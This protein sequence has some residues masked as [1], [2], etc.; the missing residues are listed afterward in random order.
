MTLTTRAMIDADLPWVLERVS[1]EEVARML[2]YDGP[3]ADM[4]ALLAA[5]SRTEPGTRTAPLVFLHQGQPVGFAEISDI[6]PVHRKGT[7]ALL[8]ADR[9]HGLGCLRATL[10]HG[11]AALNL[12]RLE[13][14]CFPDNNAIQ[15]LASRLGARHEGTARRQV[16]RNGTYSD[17]MQ[18]A[19]LADD[20]RMKNA[21]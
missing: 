7:V 8:A 1:R 19:I 15:V 12:H 9:G 10:R 6:H 5:L 4:A 11:F 2:F 3:P 16:W 18:F 17:V 14:R 20:W 21:G 13:A